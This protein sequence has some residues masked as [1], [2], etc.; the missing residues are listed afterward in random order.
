MTKSVSLS[1]E[2]RANYLQQ[3]ARME[4]AGIPAD[5]VAATLAGAGDRDRPVLEAFRRR[6]VAGS[7]PAL[8]ARSAG[9]LRDW[10]AKVIGAAYEAGRLEAGLRLADECGARAA[11]WRR[12]KSRLALPVAILV[13]G[14]FLAPLPSL[15][16]G[17]ISFPGYVL[18]G[19]GLSALLIGSTIMI[20]RLMGRRNA[21]SAVVGRAILPD[22]GDR[23]AYRSEGQAGL[24]WLC[25]PGFRHLRKW[26]SPFS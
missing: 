21:A 1:D 13:A 20:R 24:H 3:W 22:T 14:S 16:A 4:S 7:A 15:V 10:E 11:R 17:T 9:L 6:L 25:A 8:A 5:R 2:Q 12:L 26:G 19:V 18:R 23:P